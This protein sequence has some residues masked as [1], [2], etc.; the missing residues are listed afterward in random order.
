[1]SL[2][3]NAEINLHLFDVAFDLGPCVNNLI[4]QHGVIHHLLQLVTD[5]VTEVTSCAGVC[6]VVIPA[7]KH[8]CGER[9]QLVAAH[10]CIVSF[11]LD[12]KAVLSLKTGLT[13]KGAMQSGT[14][15]DLKHV[16]FDSTEPIKES[17]HGRAYVWR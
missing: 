1:M 11:A 8:H 2:H 9:E 3:K 7:G 17:E 6:Q 16:L 14:Q 5:G 13:D 10:K 15:G 4:L 12:S